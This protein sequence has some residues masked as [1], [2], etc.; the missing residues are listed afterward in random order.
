MTNYERH[1]CKLQ[2]I[3]TRVEYSR[4]SFHG[5]FTWQLVLS[6]EATKEDLENN[7]CLENVGEELWSL[8][9]EINNCPYCGLS[10]SKPKKDDGEYILFNSI[11]GSVNVL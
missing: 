2:P 5:D 8:V 6:R 9:A 3:S 7:H 10:L 1:I 4:D 11:G